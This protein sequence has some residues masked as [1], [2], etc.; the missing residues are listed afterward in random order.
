MQLGLEMPTYHLCNTKQSAGNDFVNK[1]IVLKL[2]P[3]LVYGI[4]FYARTYGKL[5]VRRFG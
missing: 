2:K 3:I 1:T 4:K 5:K